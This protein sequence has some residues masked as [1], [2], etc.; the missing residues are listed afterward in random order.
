M[1]IFEVKIPGELYR[2]W[3]VDKEL[4]FLNCLFTQG[5]SARK[6]FVHAEVEA[7][8][9]KEARQLGR[10]MCQ[11][12]TD[13]LE[14]CMSEQVDL[15][16]RQEHIKEKGAAGETAFVSIQVI[17]A[18]KGD[19]NAPPTAEQLKTI[20]KAQTTIEAEKDVEKKEALMRA[21]HWQ[22]RGRRDTESKIDRFVKFWIALEALVGFIGKKASNLKKQLVELYPGVNEQ[23][24]RRVANQLYDVR[25]N[26]VHQGVHN[27]QGL[28]T[29]LVQLENIVADLLSARL[30]LT[31]KALAQPFFSK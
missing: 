3:L 21:I 12:A 9:E 5:S 22:A 1:P 10:K 11:D 31:F 14:F 25:C 16:P 13:L 23:Q 6:F 27:P 26:I 24:I 17:P 4:S 7:K 29:K 19:E 2:N 18:A 30:D 20:A 8:D 15:S 28:E